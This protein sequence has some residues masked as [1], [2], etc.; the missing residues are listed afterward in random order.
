MAGLEYEKGLEMTVSGK[1]YIV[2]NFAHCSL[3]AVLLDF[4]L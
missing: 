3:R 4:T 1:F 2:D